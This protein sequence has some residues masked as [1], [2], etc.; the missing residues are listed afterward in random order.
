M[1]LSSPYW[2]RGLAEAG[3]G[4]EEGREE[5]GVLLTGRLSSVLPEGAYDPRPVRGRPE[6]LGPSL[7]V[8]VVVD[9]RPL[10]HDVDIERGFF[11]VEKCAGREDP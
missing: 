9:S 3:G 6:G 1:I 10:R 7:G 8:S 11:M 4:R 2:Y 5:E